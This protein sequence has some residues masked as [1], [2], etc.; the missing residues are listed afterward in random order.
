MLAVAQASFPLSRGWVKPKSPSPTELAVATGEALKRLREQARMSQE[1][2]AGVVGVSRQAWQ[3][4]EKGSR[5]LILRQDVQERLA[6]AVGSDIEMLL[7]ERAK[8]LEWVPGGARK[9]ATVREESN[10]IEIPV[11]GRA[12]AGIIGAQVYDMTEPERTIDLS[13]RY[14]PTARAMQLV[15]DSLY[16]CA[17]SGM[18]VIYDSELFPRRDQ[19]AIVTTASGEVYVKLF[20]REDAERYYFRETRQDGDAFRFHELSFA[21]EQVLSV[22]AIID[23]LD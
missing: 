1:Q 8:L 9:T 20:V 3:L 10:V 15:G 2:A 16:P 6:G 22:H 23:R 17:S 5:Q 14:G 21:K 19:G 18:T 12:R 7:F 13:R 11:W 4:Y